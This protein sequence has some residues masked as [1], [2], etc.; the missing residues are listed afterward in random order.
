M[1]WQ[2]DLTHDIRTFSEK[3]NIDD[4]IGFGYCKLK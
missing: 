4:P 2:Q 1:K 3:D